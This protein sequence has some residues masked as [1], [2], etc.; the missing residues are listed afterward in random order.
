ML[1]RHL[2]ATYPSLWPPFLAAVGVG[3][4]I[5]SV[6]GLLYA[7]SGSWHALVHDRD[8]PK[9]TGRIWHIDGAKIHGMLVVKDI[10]KFQSSENSQVHFPGIH[11]GK[12]F[13]R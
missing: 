7:T 8:D 10:R 6:L 13:L 11:E 1:S 5:T 12:T 9:I 3:S 4:A 2:T